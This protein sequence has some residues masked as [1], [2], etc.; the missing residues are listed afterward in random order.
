MLRIAALRQS[1][2]AVLADMDGL[3]EA[4][5]DTDEATG[6]NIARDLTAEEQTSFDALK[7]KADG[8]QAQIAREEDLMKRKAAAAAPVDVGG[9]NQGGGS[10]GGLIPAQPKEK[11]PAG[12]MVARI[13]QAVAV[14]Q[15]DHRAVANAAEQLYGSEMGEI[16][17]NM[18][19]S[20]DTKGGFLVDEAYSSDFIDILRPNVQ[21]RRMGARPVPMPD[22][23]LTTRKKTAGTTASYVGERV[24][25]PTTAATVGVNTM[26][27]KRLTA[28]VPITNQL[29]R[30]A[31]MNVQQMI[32][33]DLVE[34]VARTE[35]QQ[36]LRGTASATAPGGIRDLMAAGNVLTANATVNL[37]N[38]DND[39]GRLELAVIGANIPMIS[40]GYIVSPRTL[41]FLERLRDAN[42][43]KAYP[44]IAD[45]RLGMYPIGWTTSIPDNLGAGT[46]E[47]EIYFGD[48]AQ[49][50]IGETERI[51]IAASDVAA[52]DDGGTIRAAFS[53][54]ETVIRLIAEHDT[55]LRYDTAFARLDAVTWTP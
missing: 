54:D 43:N 33:D 5:V 21:V 42:G 15:Q 2:A 27:A 46:D 16:V 36:F 26:S 40:P 8:L 7:A 9:A 1:L 38:V 41:K 55:Q 14:G 31:S 4:A 50:N 23:N 22:G 49:F 28:M 24:P 34:G 37:A 20:T 44:E 11:L 10:G 53:N 51:A 32:R 45:G 35:D 29:I 13:A 19:E 6:E 18:E 30:R 25:A 39:L 52:Y 3:I 47:S 48:F 17:A 12:V